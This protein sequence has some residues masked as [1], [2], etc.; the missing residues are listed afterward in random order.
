MADLSPRDHC[1]RTVEQERFREML[2]FGSP[3]RLMTVCAKSGDGKSSLLQRLRYN[4]HRV[5]QP[6]VPC[7][8]FDLSD[9]SKE[10]TLFG[11]VSDLID[12]FADGDEDV[13]KLFTTFNQ[14]TLAKANN[15]FT[16]FGDSSGTF[17]ARFPPVQ[18]TA[19][20]G[21]MSGGKNV[22][23]EVHEV[24]AGTAN[25]APPPEFNAAQQRL[26]ND[27]L[28]A[29]FFDD[30]RAI[31]AQRPMVIMLDGWQGCERELRN[32][33][34]DRMFGHHL[35]SRDPGKRPDKLAIVVA[36]QSRGYATGEHPDGLDPSDF[37]EL[38]SSDDEFAATVWQAELSR[39]WDL[40][41][42]YEFMYKHGYRQPADL[43]EADIMSVRQRIHGGVALAQLVKLI[44]HLAEAA[45]DMPQQQ[46]LG[47][48]AS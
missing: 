24:H 15:D 21:S 39:E 27:R 37:C 8:L 45:P 26:A 10:S 35:L 47:W 43:A 29:A 7:S 12:G 34:F 13:R 9:P 22:G 36:G 2:D 40:A 16:P 17:F 48:V 14:L 30:L 32:T 44:R 23:M 18:A 42:V 31:C 28:V 38:F 46:P 6:M 33:I 1:D 19:T 4:C 20:A 5:Y 11:V 25:F 41:V 3:T